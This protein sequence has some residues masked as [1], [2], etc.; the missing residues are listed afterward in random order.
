MNFST[1]VEDSGAATDPRSPAAAAEPDHVRRR[2]VRWFL[3][4]AFGCSWLP[5]LV[6]H[7]AGG[8]LDNPVIQLLTA[9]FMPA[10]AA[11][12]VRKW[13]TGQ[14]FADSGLGLRLRTSWRYVLMA[15]LMPWG[16]LLVAL[17]VATL[18]GWDP[19]GVELPGASWAY[20]AAG[21][22][23]CVVLAPLFWGEEY[24]WTAYLR[25]RL[26]P[27]RPVATTFL[28]GVIWGVWHWP[29]PWVGYFGGNTGAAEAIWA[30]I[31]WLPLSILLEFVIGWLW[32]ETRS[33]WPGAMLHAGCNLVA[34]Q[35]MFLVLGDAVGSNATTLL[36]C[37]GLT[38]IVVAIVASGHTAGRRRNRRTPPA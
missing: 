25:D 7:L 6:V 27:G 34:A 18:A 22:L 3:V 36:L 12:V 38:P 28:T 4:L 8:S 2:G 5:W 23:I 15:I 19:A 9:A 33:V 35:G 17:G 20:L 1:A 14:G 29:L 24:G 21:P 16:V 31:L 26:C 13:I 30:M 37:A 11:C 32:S 10:I